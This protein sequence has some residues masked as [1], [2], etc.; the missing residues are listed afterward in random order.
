MELFIFGLILGWFLG[1]SVLLVY[2]NLNDLIRSKEEW[3]KAKGK[4][5]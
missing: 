2:Y 3:L 5:K 1:S 4:L